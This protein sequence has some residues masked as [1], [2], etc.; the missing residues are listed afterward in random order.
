MT[1]DKYWLMGPAYDALSWAFAG[2]AIYRCK[3]SLLKSPWLKRGDKVLV[4]GAGHGK[5]AIYAARM[6]ASVTVLDL[7][8]AML[9]KFREAVEKTGED[10][11]IRIV[12]ADIFKFEE[13]E[14]F[15]MVTGNFFFNLFPEK[16]VP[17]VLAHLKK[18]TR[19]GGYV[20]ISDFALP[21]GNPLAKLFKHLYWY[22]AIVI[23]WATTGAAI[24]PVYDYKKYMM[25]A[26][27]KMRALEHTKLLGVDAYTSMLGEKVE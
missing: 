9:N 5:E 25:K 4:A 14:Q 1:K 20:V 26:G 19:V 24:H 23:F 21:Q 16:M 13:Y 18:L 6:G 7:S 17:D 22:T 2:N 27:L 10:L 8:Q 12:H 15:D 3:C 11:D